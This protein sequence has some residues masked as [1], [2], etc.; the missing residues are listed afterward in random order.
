MPLDGRAVT[1]N[2]RAIL[3]A[4]DQVGAPGTPTLGAGDSLDIIE[5][6][7][8]SRFSPGDV[9]IDRLGIRPT[10]KLVMNSFKAMTK[11]VKSD[12]LF[13]VMF[14]GHGKGASSS[15]PG[16]AWSLTGDEVF[17]DLDLA[18]ALLEFPRRVD[19]VVISN[20]CYGEGIFRVDALG[21]R[22]AEHLPRNS[23]MVCVSAAGKN[24]L[25]EVAKLVNLAS[26]TVAA[27]VARQSYTQLSINFAAQAVAGCEFH[28]DARPP[29]RRSELVL[30]TERRPTQPPGRV[31]QDA[32]D[33]RSRGSAR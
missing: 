18:T 11:L 26:E 2:V 16:Q 28:V 4:G 19:T 15:A 22:L 9:K 21:H 7:L 24:D 17:T 33:R 3:I 13:V 8:T 25:V 12:E 5:H 20:C 30:S 31:V 6:D 23:P 10:N 1:R 32:T 14:A 29:S 27:A